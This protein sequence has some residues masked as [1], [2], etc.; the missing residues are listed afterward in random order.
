MTSVR[1]VHLAGTA[2]AIGGV[3]WFMLAV[4]QGTIW[5]FEPPPGSAA[6]YVIE[7]IFVIAQ[8][9][10]LFGFFGVLWS[11]GI[12]RSLFG[13]IAFGLGVLGHVVFVAGEIHSLLLGSISDLIP[14]G[15]L[16]SAVGMLLTGVAVLVAKQWQGRARWMPLLAGLYPW[17]VMFP[18]IFIASEPNVYAV[19]GWGL[20]RLALGLA[21]RAQANVVPVAAPPTGAQVPQRGA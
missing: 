21:I 5:G 1:R 2:Y 13:R 15:A 12:G 3:V 4:V 14:L 19:G 11:G 16:T 8:L 17:L 18:F 6:F 10:L 20:A 7:A 9:L